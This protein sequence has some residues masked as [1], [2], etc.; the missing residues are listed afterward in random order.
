VIDFN[1]QANNQ[2]DDVTE[3]DRPDTLNEFITLIRNGEYK[4]TVNMGGDGEEPLTGITLQSEYPLPEDDVHQEFERLF[5]EIAIGVCRI[6]DTHSGVDEAY[7]IGRVIQHAVEENDVLTV[8]VIGDVI[9][10]PGVTSEELKQCV[11]FASLYPNGG[12]PS[13]VN[14]PMVCEMKDKYG[15]GEVKE[16]VEKISES[17]FSPSDEVM[18]VY[19]NT[20]VITPETVGKAL[21]E[22]GVDDVL[23]GVITAHVIDQKEIPDDVESRVEKIQRERGDNGEM[24]SPGALNSNESG[25]KENESDPV[26]NRVKERERGS[27]SV[28]ESV[29]SE[30][31]ANDG[32]YTSVSEAFEAAINRVNGSEK[33]K[34]IDKYWQLGDVLLRF[35]QGHGLTYSEM[36][37]EFDIGVSR[38]YGVHARTLADVF[39]YKQYPDNVTVSSV[40]S[41]NNHTES[42]EETRDVVSR[43]GECEADITQIY[44]DIWRELDSPTPN[45]IIDYM[46]KEGNR[47]NEKS[48][49]AVAALYDTEETTTERVTQALHENEIISTTNRKSNDGNIGEFKQESTEITP[50]SETNTVTERVDS[51]SKS[52]PQSDANRESVTAYTDV[53]QSDSTI[54][55]T[56]ENSVVKAHDELYETVIGDLYS[57][58]LPSVNVISLLNCFDALTHVDSGNKFW[59]AVIQEECAE[60][61]VSTLDVN[62]AS[63]EDTHRADSKQWVTEY[64]TGTPYGV[65]QHTNECDEPLLFTW[66]SDD[67]HSATLALT[68]Y[69]ANGGDVVIYI[70]ESRGGD[71][72]KEF[73]TT[74]EKHYSCAMYVTP[75]QWSSNADAVQVYTRTGDVPEAI[76]AEG[77]KTDAVELVTGGGE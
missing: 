15:D 72:P 34:G 17:E 53:V 61:R 64:D 28:A 70:G 29:I 10:V 6:I 75:M 55:T 47:V 73:L 44:V 31:E 18:S 12:F 62:E 69:A 37:D 11:E 14:V 21:V 46:E 42:P 20:E 32:V 50:S 25:V 19:Q 59:S 7:E 45:E 49:R 76:T 3:K 54:T 8:D 23:N 38:T 74:L 9:D 39:E 36:F 60:T 41:I 43:V 40:Y 33:Y 68:T 1:M 58:T 4:Y 24:Q 57:H 2:S 5:D 13:D 35:K 52:P 56:A 16:V 67:K 71:C 51:P 66:P 65:I 48:V 27:E 30:L 22:N 63:T 26:S 77:C